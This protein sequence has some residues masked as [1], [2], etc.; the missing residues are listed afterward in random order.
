[1]LVPV[2]VCGTGS[3]WPGQGFWVR[4]GSI[5][6]VAG[7]VS[8]ANR[9]MGLQASAQLQTNLD[10]MLTGGEM[11]R[12]LADLKPAPVTFQPLVPYLNNAAKLHL[13]ACHRHHHLE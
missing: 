2:E 5:W 8:R 3:G 1:M 7:A 4:Q 12:D 11:I 10:D 6:H 13:E 9:A